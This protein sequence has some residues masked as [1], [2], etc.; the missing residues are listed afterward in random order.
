MCFDVW[1]KTSSRLDSVSIVRDTVIFP[2]VVDTRFAFLWAWGDVNRSDNS[3]DSNADLLGL[4]TE[5]DFRGSTVALDAFYLISEGDDDSDGVFLGASAIQ[6]IGE[7]NTAFYVNQSIALDRRQVTVDDGTLLFG[8][9]SLTPLGSHNLVYANAFWGIDNFSSASRGETNGGP[10]GRV[11][12]LFASSGIG[13]YPAALGNGVEDAI[14]GA[15]GYQ[16][17]FNDDKTQL[18][19]ELG[20]V[21]TTDDDSSVQNGIGAGVRFQHKFAERYLFQVD[22]FVADR[23]RADETY[24]I[25]S[26]WR[27][28]F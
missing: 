3:L 12:L 4:V 13:T 25:K 19:G 18:V 11:G 1:Q 26:E 21:E 8:E 6:R 2:N 23:E 22:G 14:G 27:V 5:S 24:G 9:V 10:I 16:M 17:L 7:F 20:F 15:V 28:Q